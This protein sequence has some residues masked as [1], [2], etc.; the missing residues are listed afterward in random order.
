MS[1]RSTKLSA[2]TS[3]PPTVNARAPNRSDSQPDSGAETRNPM[4]SGTR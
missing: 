4:V 2:V 1:I 3:A